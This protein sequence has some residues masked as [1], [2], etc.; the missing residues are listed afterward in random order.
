MVG[1]S[2]SCSANS[3][4]PRRASMF[5]SCCGARLSFCAGLAMYLA[6]VLLVFPRYLLGLQ[7]TLDQVSEWL[8]WYSGVPIVAGLG[9]RRWSTCL[10]FFERRKP[11][12]PVRYEPLANRSVTVA[13]T[14]YNDEDSIADA[15][16]DFRAH[17][18]VARVI[19]VSNNS[20][21][22]HLRARRSGGRDHLQRAAAGLW[23]LRLPLPDRGGAL[24]RHRP[25]R[26]VRRRPDL[27]R[28]RHREIARLCPAQRHRERHAHRRTA[29]PAGHPAE[30]LHVLWQCLRRQVARGQASRPRHDHRRRHDLQI[31]PPRRACSSCCPSS[32]RR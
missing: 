20:S 17:P 11:D 7:S 29:A 14:A 5:R 24:R 8:V 3:G 6:G 23:P 18:L 32:T 12:V 2:T 4:S 25:R 9:A 26:P 19:V 15:V 1:R 10:F 27:P 30:H 28:L 31:V 22:A 21:D 13:L 16:A